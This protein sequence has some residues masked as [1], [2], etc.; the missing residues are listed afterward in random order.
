MRKRL[1][2]ALVIAFWTG[3][4]Q[5]Q[6]VSR[7]DLLARSMRARAIEAV[8]WGMPAVNFDLMLQAALKAGAKENQIV[9]WS[10]SPDRKNQT[11]TPNPSTI[12]SERSHDLS[13]S[14]TISRYPGHRLYWS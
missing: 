1:F 2:I 12:Y 5:A 3:W 9:F 6:A 14:A 7:D 13:R 4:A 10:R 8:I 11:P